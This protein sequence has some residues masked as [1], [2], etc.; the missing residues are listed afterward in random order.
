[1]ILKLKACLMLKVWTDNQQAGLLDRNRGGMGLGASFAYLP[2]ADDARAVSLTMPKR[3]QSYEQDYGLHPIFEM[4]L[5]EGAFASGSGLRLQKPPGALMTLTSYPLS[6]ALKWDV[7][8]IRQERHTLTTVCRFN[9]S[10][11]FLNR[12]ARAAL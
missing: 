8:A 12:A 10:M 11:K 6:G 2:D 7:S 4:N 5:P 1:M 9:R 3:L